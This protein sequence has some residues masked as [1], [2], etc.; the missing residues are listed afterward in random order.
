M[1]TFE[2]LHSWYQKRKSWS[3]WLSRYFYLWGGLVDVQYTCTIHTKGKG[4]GPNEQRKFLCLNFSH[5]TLKYEFHFIKFKHV[6]YCITFYCFITVK[7]NEFL[8]MILHSSSKV[9]FFFS[10]LYFSFFLFF[11]FP[12]IIPSIK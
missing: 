5:L 12:F 2:G 6:W 11:L 7:L 10:F 4:G 1:L 9:F 8:L 3:L